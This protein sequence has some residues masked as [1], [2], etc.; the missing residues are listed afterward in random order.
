MGHTANY[1][2]VNDRLVI[3]GG[4]GGSDVTPSYLLNDVCEIPLH[5]S[6]A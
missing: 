3:F 5:G 1:D 2:P 4:M 6:P